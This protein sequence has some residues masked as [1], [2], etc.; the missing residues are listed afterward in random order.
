[1][2][3]ISIKQ[4]PHIQQVDYIRA[5]ASLAV[6]LFHL[7]GKTLPVLNYGW[8]GVYM[9]FLLSGFI[10][11]WAIPENYTWRL[12]GRFVLKRIIR[13]EPPYIISICIA[14]IVN[15][16]WVQHYK[17]DWINA[18]CHLAYLNS[19]LGQ[20][21]LSPVY[22]TLGIEFQFYLFVALCFPLFTRN[23]GQWLL[24]VLSVLAVFIK[25]P[26]ASLVNSFPVFALGVLYYLYLVKG[27]SLKGTLILGV[28]IAV[29]SY[30]AVGIPQTLA[31]LFSLG[32]LLLPLKKHPFISFF[33]RIS[34]SLYLT[35]DMI[36]S[37]LVVYLGTHLPKLLFFKGIEFL[38][39]I[40]V[41]ILFAWLFYRLIEM[42]CLKLSKRIVYKA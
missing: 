32:L 19:F 21:Y 26:G 22:W 27:K 41:S 39:G 4:K 10:I 16:L 29:C 5:I 14:I 17:P 7:G 18:L 1:M 15:F 28:L 42:P 30:Y 34:F 31:A 35:H 24:L 13:I 8:L 12:S 40:G 25:V 6:A 37:H 33:S 38:T 36:G 23:W 9:F 3:A 2:A 11:C 20:P